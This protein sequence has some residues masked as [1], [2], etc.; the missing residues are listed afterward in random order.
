MAP[1]R[2]TIPTQTLLKAEEVSK[3]KVLNASAIQ[4]KAAGVQ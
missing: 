4:G 1:E 3:T 2:L